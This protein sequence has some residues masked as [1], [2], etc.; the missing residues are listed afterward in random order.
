[1][2]LLLVTNY[3]YPPMSLW[4]LTLLYGTGHFLL[5]LCVFSHAY[6]GV[7]YESFSQYI[8]SHDYLV[9]WLLLNTFN[10][11]MCGKFMLL[12]LTFCTHI[13]FVIWGVYCMYFTVIALF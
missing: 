10:A 4:I 2:L 6:D 7:V 8:L 12:A 1:M 5:H 9:S 13:C 11:V 3:H